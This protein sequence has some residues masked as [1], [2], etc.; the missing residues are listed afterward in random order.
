MKQPA[1]WA[2]V[3]N[4][5]TGPDAGTPTKVD[6][7]SNVNGFIR[8]TAAS[9]QAVNFVLNAQGEAA[10]RALGAGALTLREL[11]SE[12]LVV[13]DAAASMAAAAVGEGFPIVL[14]KTT[15]ALGTNDA[16]LLDSLGVIVNLTSLVA[17][18]ACNPLT[19]RILISGQAAGVGGFAFSDDSGETWTAGA[20]GAIVAGSNGLV[21][22]APKGKFI[23]ADS[24]TALRSADGSAAWASGTISND[25]SGG[26]AVLSSGVTVACGDG[27]AVAFSLSADGGATWSDASGTVPNAGSAANAGSL[28]GNGGAKIYHLAEM[29]G[30]GTFQASSSLD[31]NTWAAAKTFVVSGTMAR[32]RILACQNTGLLVALMPFTPAAGTQVITAVSFSVDGTEWSDLSYYNNAPIAAF[33]VAGGRLFLTQGSQLFGSAGVGWR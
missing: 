26:L 19:K 15:Q 17:N 13:I 31:G 6:P 27:A 11:R 9:A 10:R 1:K 7:A 23:A 22:N 32:P 5:T 29:T 21:W 18:A 24:T 25:S 30:L 4:Y 14:A 20:A 12:G 3:L 33:A 28:V 16:G 8:G 2:T